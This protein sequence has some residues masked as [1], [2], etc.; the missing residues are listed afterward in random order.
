MS[1]VNVIHL[2]PQHDYSTCR[3]QQDRTDR[4]AR[5]SAL[6]AYRDQRV[7]REYGGHSRN[8]KG[9]EPRETNL[10]G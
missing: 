7:N 6:Q 4:D 8:S 2:K 9:E 3:D 1:E 10:R 5:Q